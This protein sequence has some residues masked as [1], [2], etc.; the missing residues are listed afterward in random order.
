M[1]TAFSATKI[2]DG[3][4]AFWRL[5]FASDVPNATFRIYLNG[6]RVGTR[7]GTE[8]PP[9]SGNDVTGFFVLSV[10]EG[11]SPVID[12]LDDDTAAAPDGNPD[13][14][15][16]VW[17]SPGGPLSAATVDY[18]R[19]D[20]NIGSIWTETA[21]VPDTGAGYFTW[22]SEP[23]AD[24]VTHQFRVVPVGQNGNPGTAVTF[25]MLVV[26]YPDPPAVTYAF[27]PGTG[28]VTI[29]AAS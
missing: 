10:P 7:A 29:A 8:E 1:I 28:T 26:R 23:L 24:G 20:E 6:V 21:Y 27:N 12:V 5:D 22:T 13:Y 4:P 9:G 3:D 19:I 15:T 16:L 18:Y 25:L 14:V 17:Y 2:S 11:S